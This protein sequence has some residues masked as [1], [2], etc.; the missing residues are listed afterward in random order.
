MYII[1]EK[2]LKY[3]T[4]DLG[5][6]MLFLLNGFIFLML[7]HTTTR[8]ST[9]KSRTAATMG[10]QTESE[11]KKRKTPEIVMKMDYCYNQVIIKSLSNSL[12]RQHQGAWSEGYGATAPK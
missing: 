4:K 11:K 6:M 7:Q 5:N 2:I 3:I 12:Y 8:V 1:K 10:I 9:R